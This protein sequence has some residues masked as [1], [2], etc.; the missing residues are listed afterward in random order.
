MPTWC[1]MNE[2]KKIDLKHPNFNTMIERLSKT[3]VEK[4]VLWFYEMLRSFCNKTLGPS[5]T[6]ITIIYLHHI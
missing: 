1:V 2:P 5:I 4:M 3:L 6:D